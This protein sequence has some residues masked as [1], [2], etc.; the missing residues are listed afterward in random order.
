[1]ACYSAVFGYRVKAAKAS[2]GKSALARVAKWKRSYLNPHTIL[3]RIM[4][5]N[6]E[7]EGILLE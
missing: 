6:D 4:R 5:I 7:D 3:E 1:M 2:G